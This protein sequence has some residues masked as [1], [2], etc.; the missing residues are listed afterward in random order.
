MIFRQLTH[1][2]LGCASYLIGDDDAGV[3]AVVDPRLDIDEYLRLARYLGVRIEH[4]IETHTHAD[5]VSGHGRLVAATGA[6][7]HIHRDAAPAYDHEPIDEGWELRLGA[8]AVRALHT[9]GHRPEHTAFTLTDTGRS[10]EPWAVLTGDSL[11]VGDIARPDL[12]VDREEGARGIFRSL[13][14]A[15]LP[16]PDTVEV[17][18]GHLGG[19]MCGGP[20]MDLKICSTIGFERATQDLLGIA[21]EDAFVERALAGLGPQPPNFRAIVEL[22][23]GP[24]LREPLDAHPLTPRQVRAAAADGALV[25]DVRTGFQFDEAHVPGAVNITIRRAGF[26]SKLAWIAQPGQPLVFAGR[27]DETAL[28]AAGL[29]AAVGVREVAGYLSGGMTAWRDERL[30]V[31]RVARIDVPGLHERWRAGDGVQVLDVRERAEW[32]AGHIPGSVH[33]PYHDVRG[34]PAGIDPARPVAVVCGSGQRSAVATGLLR[35]GGVREP[36]HVV[37]GGVPAWARAGW[38]I[39]TGGA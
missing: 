14:G 7:I 24:L 15:L 25:V 21:D 28:Q 38:P 1:D 23:R 31:E 10:D 34:V 29:A 12:A 30:P 4:V 33:M 39:A 20:G 5:H 6:T 22:N 17:W 8:L 19:S 11:F 13:R 35:R 37:D 16:L 27:D 3:A 18:P 36:L 26:G 9:P 2:D 32:E